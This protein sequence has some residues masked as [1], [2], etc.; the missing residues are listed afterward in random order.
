MIAARRP[1]PVRDPRPANVRRGFTLIELIVAAV[2]IALI[3]SGIVTAVSNMVRAKTKSVGRQQAFARADAAGARIAVDLASAVRS[4]DLAQCR[5]QVTDSGP[6]HVQRDGLTVLMRSMRT[7]RGGEDIPEGG[8]Y[9]A[10]YRVDGGGTT[11]GLWRRVDPAFDL[12]LDAGGIASLLA[13]GVFSFSV[14]ASDGVAWF[15]AWDS[16]SDGM[17]H[18]VRVTIRAQ[19]DD[20]KADATVRRV[21][22]IDRVPTPPDAE[23]TTTPAA[24]ESTDGTTGTGGTGGG[25]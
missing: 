5:V 6:G 11:A 2:I 19:S 15:E 16:D 4:A 18:A 25:G 9:E 14:E 3:G 7:V 23:A 22:A 13:A 24:G 1:S 8:E 17:P 12:A 20:G 21:V 10:Q